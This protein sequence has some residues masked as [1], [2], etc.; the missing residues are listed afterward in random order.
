MWVE[1]SLRGSTRVERVL[2]EISHVSVLVFLIVA[3]G[4]GLVASIYMSS[5]YGTKYTA[6]FVVVCILFPVL[7]ALLWKQSW[8]TKKLREALRRQETEPNPMNV[9]AGMGGDASFKLLVLTPD[10]EVCFVNQAYLQYA[11]CTPEQVLGFKI[12]EVL[13][14]EGV[15]DRA[16]MLLKQTDPPNMIMSFNTF[17]RV[18]L[19]DC[20]PAHITMTRIAPKQGEMCILVV[21]RDPP[22][23][24]PGPVPP[25]HGYVC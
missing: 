14:A 10:L 20:R 16:T 19:E 12:H 11:S 13:D 21:V 7:F 25:N 15:E 2:R 8:Q 23:G 22:F 9:I 1:R 17:V 3:V 5:Q 24:N 4:S 6:V 18:G